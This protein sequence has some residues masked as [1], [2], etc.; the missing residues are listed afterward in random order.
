MNIQNSN[1]HVAKF[2]TS[3]SNSMSKMSKED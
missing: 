3:M 2:K 1:V